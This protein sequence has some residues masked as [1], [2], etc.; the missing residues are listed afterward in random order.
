MYNYKI[1][2][3]NFNGIIF[4]TFKTQRGQRPYNTEKKHKLITLGFSPK[5]AFGQTTVSKL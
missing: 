5:A 4:E 2:L 3:S 1:S